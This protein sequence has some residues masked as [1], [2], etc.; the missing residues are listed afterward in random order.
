M[1]NYRESRL[2]AVNLRGEFFKAFFF[3]MKEEGLAELVSTQPSVREV[4]STIPRCDLKS[5]FRLL[6]FLCSF[7]Y[8]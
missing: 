4:L 8:A 5:F 6:P 3:S 7:K 2:T 1:K